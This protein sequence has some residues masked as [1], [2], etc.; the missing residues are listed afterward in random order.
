[1]LHGEAVALGMTLAF[2]FSARLGLTAPAEADRV[3]AHLAAVGLPTRVSEIPG[4]RPSVGQ[5]M[6]LIAQDK[7]VERGRLTFILARGVG[8]SFV[9]PDVDAA[10]VRA[11]LADKLAD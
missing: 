7:K 6:E 1:L 8:R 3:T 5:L 4:E 2:A 11:F 10:D 9:A